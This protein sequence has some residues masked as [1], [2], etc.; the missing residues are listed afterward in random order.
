MG[1][2]IILGAQLPKDWRLNLILQKDEL[3]QGMVR[4][5]LNETNPETKKKIA[6]EM[7]MYEEKIAKENNL[8]KPE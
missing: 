7:T 4:K 8:P 5:W 2:K 3:Y 6:A 1:A